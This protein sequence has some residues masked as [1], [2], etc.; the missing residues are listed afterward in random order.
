M[1]VMIDSG[2]SVNILDE[3]A[4]AQIGSPKL[5]TKHLPKLLPYGGGKSITLKGKCNLTIEKN[6]KIEIATFHIVKGN[7]GS[8]LG[9]KTSCALHIVEIIHNIDTEHERFL[10]LFNGIGKLKSKTVKIHIDTTVKPV[11]QT[12]RR[13]PFHLRGKVEDEINKLLSEDVIEK[14]TDQPT[15]WISPIVTPPKKNPDEIRLC[16]DMREA[17]KA[18]K[19]ERHLL[20]TIDALINDLNGSKVFS[21]LD[22]KSGYHQLVLDEES[23]YITTFN[24]HLGL[25]RY[26]RLNFGISSASEVFQDTI[27]NVIK[28]I[29]GTKNISDDII[30]YGETQADHD[31]ALQLVFDRLVTHGLTLNKQ[32]CEYNKTSITFFGVVFSGKGVSAD[33]IKVAAIKDMQAPKDASEIR[34][35][36]GMTGYCSRFIQDYAHITEPLRRLT[37]KT[38]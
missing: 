2:A 22:L 8:L 13:T 20:P 14:V 30:V 15:P 10:E 9:Y 21:K 3:K 5:S 19:R 11:A 25:F 34:S 38:D 26:K 7:N 12:Q 16:V 1:T 24:T 35:F 4:Y 29:K 27:R 33:P 6:G 17:N 32:K 28:G 36:L 18:I 37:K 23:R 31:K